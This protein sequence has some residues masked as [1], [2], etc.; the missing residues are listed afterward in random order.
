[1]VY[2]RDGAIPVPTRRQALE[3]VKRAPQASGGICAVCGCTEFNA[4]INDQNG[5]AC[6]WA[7]PEQTLC[8]AC[9]SKSE[10]S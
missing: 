9:E 10:T 6:S 2:T 4:C 8:T 7:N 3:Q 1:M 5:Q